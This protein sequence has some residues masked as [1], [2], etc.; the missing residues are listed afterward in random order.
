MTKRQILNK[1]IKQHGDCTG[2]SC[3]GDK[4]PLFDQCTKTNK[5]KLAKETLATFDEGDMKCQEKK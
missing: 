5:L 3:L 1:I 2:I 4:C